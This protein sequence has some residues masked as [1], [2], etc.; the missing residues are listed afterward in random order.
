MLKPEATLVSLLSTSGLLML[1]MAACSPSPH[2]PA[3]STQP[4]TTQA[5]SP[6][7]PTWVAGPS[8]PL[9]QGFPP[10][11]PVGTIIIKHYGPCR[12]ALTTSSSQRQGNGSLFM[13]LFRHIESN[14]IAMSSPVVMTYHAVEPH[15]AAADAGTP[16][17]KI[18][19]MAFVY[20]STRI[21]H[22]GSFGPV[23]VKDVPAMTVAS[24][25]VRGS[26]TA[27]R[28]ARAKAKLDAWLAAHAAEYRQ[29]GPAR[30][31]GYNSP[32]VLP[33]LRFGEVQIPIEPV[34][35]AT[36]ETNSH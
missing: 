27:G 25:G 15:S 19:S 9:P 29:D 24:I 12:M 6:A 36:T 7:K 34:A 11:G 3:A 4:P 5:A 26:Y 32:F 23:Q 13:P 28:F 22:D 2:T 30:Y 20:Q 16:A 14:H 31:L 21:G 18:N 33:F 1:A 17:E 8:A 35:A 10:P